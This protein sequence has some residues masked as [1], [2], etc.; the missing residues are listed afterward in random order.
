MKSIDTELVNRIRHDIVVGTHSRAG[1]LNSM[2]ISMG[3][4][5]LSAGGRLEREGY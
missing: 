2:L 3:I 4:A 5:Y 1:Y